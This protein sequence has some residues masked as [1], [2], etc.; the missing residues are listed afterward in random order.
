MTDDADL[1]IGDG[2]VFVIDDDDEVRGSLGSLFRS[3]G[4]D[5]AL[6]ESPAEFLKAEQ[7]AGAACLVLD[8]RLPGINGLDFQE[9]LAAEG[10]DIPV[11]FIT[12]HG[13]IPMTVR[14]MKLGAVDFLPK[15][16]DDD[17]MLRA[18]AT[19]LARYRERQAGAESVASIKE[20]YGRLTPREREVLGLVVAGLMNKQVA[21]K[22]ELSEIT[23]KIHRGNV[24]RKMEAQSLADLVRMAEALGVRDDNVRRFKI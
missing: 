1:E 16:F 24:M 6:H 12:G 3:A 17:Q 2:C 7:P 4:L 5:V 18:V 11:I 15:P 20:N 14:G 22:L 10:K 21:A 9:R 23:V 19:A 13:D 8:I